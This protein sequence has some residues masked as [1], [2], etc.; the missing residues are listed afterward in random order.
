MRLPARVGI[1]AGVLAAIGIALFLFIRPFHAAENVP[2]VHF[3]DIDNA[4]AGGYLGTARDLIASIEVLPKSEEDLVELL[5]R[6]FRVCSATG[7]YSLLAHLGRK[8][9][10]RQPGS[11]RIRAIAGYGALRVG[12]LSEADHVLSRGVMPAGVGELLRAEA[13][14]RRG[15]AWA[16]TDSL[17][18]DLVAL[19]GAD[20]AA[21]FSRAAL[22]VGDQ[23]LSLDAALLDMKQGALPEARLLAQNA[24]TE[25]RFDEPTA[26]ILYDA[27]DLAGARQRLS[28]LQAVRPESAALALSMADIFQETGNARESEDWLLKALP[29][30]PA[31]TWTVYA[32]LA[33]FSSQRGD[34]AGAARRIDDGLAFFPRSRELRL[35]QAILAVAMDQQGRAESILSSLA[36]ESP[37]DAEPALILLSLRAPSMSPE[38]Y[39]GEMW[40]LFNRT[41]A[42]T[43][44]FDALCATLIAAHDWEGAELA[45]RYYESASGA[46]EAETLLVAGMVAAQRG[47]SGA[48]VAALRRS[49]LLARDPRALYDLGLVYLS[50][51]NARAARAELDAAAAEYP[52]PGDSI[53]ARQTLGRIETFRGTAHML[54]GDNP[55]ARTALLHS[56]A[57]DPRNLRAVLELRKLD[58]G[59]Q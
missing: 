43:G 42:S 20:N 7:D 23:R 45:L 34:L 2:V 35:P 21:A 38:A 8:A 3:P 11:A 19:T 50:V 58:A 49:M 52:S 47:N 18:R 22:R 51:G 6:G 56:L 44:V 24:L 33:L 26:F 14:L 30:G 54:D 1:G 13:A 25:D 17:T 12:Q 29:L 31:L 59:S 16:G 39:R 48:A 57:L 46:P 40:K 10:D 32:N 41:P 15:A 55:G 37:G 5:K 36:A 28:R 4:I 53:D 9:L 27:G